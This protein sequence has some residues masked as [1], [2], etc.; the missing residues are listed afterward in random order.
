M[1][2]RTVIFRRTVEFVAI[3]AYIESDQSHV[4]G[5]GIRGV[6]NL[7]I[8]LR[9]RRLRRQGEGMTSTVRRKPVI[10]VGLLLVLLHLAACFSAQ[11]ARAQSNVVRLA[12]VNTPAESGLLEDLLPDFERQTGLRV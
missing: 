5:A 7:T 1:V 11:E 9:V 6:V 2:F 12:V 4:R 10:Q 3:R 8:G